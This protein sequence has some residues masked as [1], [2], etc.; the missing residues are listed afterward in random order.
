MG[1]CKCGCG[2]T[3]NK[4]EYNGRFNKYKLGEHFDY[5]RGHHSKVENNPNWNGGRRTT[6]SGYIMLRMSDGTYL[7]EHRIVAEKAL[8]KKLPNTAYVHHVDENRKN[9]VNTNLVICNDNAYHKLLH[10]RMRALRI[11]GHANWR[12]CE[13]CKCY[14]DPKNLYLR[15]SGKGGFH[16]QCKKEKRKLSRWTA[17]SGLDVLEALNI[18][19]LIQSSRSQTGIKA[20]KIQ[21]T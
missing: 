18:P 13:I 11:C 9:N 20:P 19:T 15:P 12:K 7:M 4:A 6:M 21:K 17:Y 5:I 16:R 3:T 8:G 14:D 10:Q 1:L 2:K